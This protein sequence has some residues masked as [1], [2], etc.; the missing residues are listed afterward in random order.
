MKTIAD[1]TVVVMPDDG[2]WAAYVP[3]IPGC[4]A[5]GDSP[6]EARLELDGVFEMFA[7]DYSISGEPMPPDLKELAPV[8][9]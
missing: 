6:A 5:I 9:G 4:H 7:D 8:A 1:Y 2:T 3:A